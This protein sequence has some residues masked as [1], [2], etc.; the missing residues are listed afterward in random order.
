MRT[1]GRPHFLPLARP[2]YPK[3]SRR[4]VLPV[5]PEG[6]ASNYFRGGPP[7][8]GGGTT[9][10]VQQGGG[11][12]GRPTSESGS[13]TLSWQ[14]TWRRVARARGGSRSKPSPWPVPRL[15]GHG[16]CRGRLSRRE[17]G[18]LSQS[19]SAS[20]WAAPWLSVAP[21]DDARSPLLLYRK[22]QPRQSLSRVPGPIAPDRPSFSLTAGCGVLHLRT[23]RNPSR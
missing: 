5:R 18:A 3:A 23:S 4:G 8:A 2:V 11:G 21:R 20:S 12:S 16:L 19:P 13:A 14:A 10:T 6:Y 9:V 17:T 1:S 15:D 7:G 22:T